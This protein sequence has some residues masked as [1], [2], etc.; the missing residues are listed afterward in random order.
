MPRTTAR[1]SLGLL[2]TCL[3]FPVAAETCS[4]R[5]SLCRA[6]CTPQLVGSGEQYGGTVEGCVASCGSRLK[7]CLRTG[8]WVHMGARNRGMQQ[9][10]ERR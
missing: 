9:E 8:I 1:L 5:A 6:A 10:V 3:S 4:G 2:V 7:S